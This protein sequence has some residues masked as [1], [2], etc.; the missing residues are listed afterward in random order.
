MTN[1]EWET[2][3]NVPLTHGESPNR[4]PTGLRVAPPLFPTFAGKG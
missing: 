3:A 4:T 1:V 2:L